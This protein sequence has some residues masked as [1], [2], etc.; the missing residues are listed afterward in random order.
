MINEQHITSVY[1]RDLEAVQA[2]LMKMAGMVEAAIKNS[3]VAL[4]TGDL[5]LAEQIRK[6][7]KKIDELEIM[8]HDEAVKVIAL[9]APAASDLRIMMSVLRVLVNLERIG[10][11][12]KNIAKRVG[13]M[14]DMPILDSAVEH[15]V[16]MSEDVGLMLS[17]SL[18]AYIQRNTELAQAVILRDVDVDRM[19]NTLFRELL[20]HMMENPANITVAM[21][22]HFIAKNIERMGDHVTSIAEMVIFI[23]TGERPDD[24]RPKLATQG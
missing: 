13:I 3:A 10:D 7:D 12:A 16:N 2:H 11:Y 5:D 24:E 8:I 6:D 1:D 9:R 20:T 14:A 19:Y 23:T 18:D 15:L 4:K 17:Q 22:L 21:H